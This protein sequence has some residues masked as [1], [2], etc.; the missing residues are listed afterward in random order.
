VLMVTCGGCDLIP[1]CSVV[2]PGSES[3]VGLDYK[4]N[5]ALPA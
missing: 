5:T 1:G 3:L 4:K 2:F